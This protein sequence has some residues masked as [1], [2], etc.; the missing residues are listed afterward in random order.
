MQVLLPS[1]SSCVTC[2]SVTLSAD[3]LSFKKLIVHSEDIPAVWGDAVLTQSF[4]IVPASLSLPALNYSQCAAGS[5]RDE[6]NGSLHRPVIQNPVI[7][8]PFGSAAQRCD[9]D[10]LLAPN[11]QTNFLPNNSTSAQP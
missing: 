7:C 4:Q 9:C 3:P 1:S 11:Y 10:S 5:G 8:R 6:G 2:E